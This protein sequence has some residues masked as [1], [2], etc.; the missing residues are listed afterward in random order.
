MKL[1]VPSSKCQRST[2]RQTSMEARG[3]VEVCDLELL[4]SLELGIWS[5]P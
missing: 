1:Q 2:K 3:G 5:F 4:W